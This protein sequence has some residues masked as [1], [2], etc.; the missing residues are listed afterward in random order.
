[1]SVEEAREVTVSTN[2]GSFVPP[3]RRV[4]DILTLLSQPG[5]FDPEIVTKTKSRADAL[6][7]EA[8]GIHFISEMILEK[9]I[10]CIFSMYRYLAEIWLWDIPAFNQPKNLGGYYGI[11]MGIRV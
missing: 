1:M 3:P 5:Q 2:K 11:G 10:S 7:P 4:D 9:L 8:A 6:P